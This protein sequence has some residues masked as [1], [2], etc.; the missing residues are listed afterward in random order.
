M[1]AVSFTKTQHQHT[2]FKSCGRNVRPH[3]CPAA[4]GHL[5]FYFALFTDIQSSGAAIFHAQ[6]HVPAQP[7]SPLED[8]RI[9]YADEDQGRPRGDFAAARQGPQASVCKT[10]LP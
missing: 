2:N 5:Y 8:A 10:R 7:S 9:S 1:A 3:V 4:V 6:T